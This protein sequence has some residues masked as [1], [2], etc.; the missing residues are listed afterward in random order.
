MSSFL[1]ILWEPGNVR[2]HCVYTDLSLHGWVNAVEKRVS[3]TNGVKQ[4]PQLLVRCLDLCNK[5]NL[6]N[7]TLYNLVVCTWVVPFLKWRF[8][9][10]H[11]F[12]LVVINLNVLGFFKYQQLLLY[13][14]P[15]RKFKC[16][17]GRMLKFINR[18]LL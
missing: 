15:K 5:L 13:S 17:L 12:F 8:V 18:S 9:F 2:H 14:L 7:V 3:A 11:L 1:I 10:S 16:H 4:K 6:D